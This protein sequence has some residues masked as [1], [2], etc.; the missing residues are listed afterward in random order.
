MTTPHDRIV[1]AIDAAPVIEGE[2]DGVL[3]ESLPPE[4]D[5]PEPEPEGIDP[6]VLARC[7]ALDQNDTDNGARLLAH[8]GDDLIHVREI[9][10]HGW[11]GRHWDAEGGQDRAER[12]AQEVARRIKLESAHMEH[13]PSDAIAM[14]EAEPLR[15]RPAEELSDTEKAILRR[16]DEADERLRK[17]RGDRRK[18]AISSG[19]RSRTVAMIAQAA[20]HCTVAP[21]ALDADPMK[22]NVA[23]GTLVFTKRTSDIIDLEC[24]DPDVTR[25]T[26]EIDVGVALAPHDR[27]DHIAKIAEVA[28]DQ[29]AKCPTFDAFLERF[30]PEEAQRRFL[31]VAAGRALIGGAASQVLIFLY[32]EGANGKSVLMDVISNVLGG[33]AGRLK[34]ES[35]T[36][37]M[38][39][40]GDKATPDFARL[41]GKRFVA[42]AELPR[43]AP[44]REGL[45]KTL[46]GSEPIPVRNLNKGFFDL[47]PEF[48]PWMS[49]NHMPEISGIDRGIWRRMKFVKFP[50]SIP[51]AE[52]KPMPEVV[53]SLMAEASGILNWLVEGALTFLREG[54][55]DPPSV[56]ALNAELKSDAD[57]VGNFLRDCVRDAIW[58]SVQARLL[59]ESFKSYCLA[60]A[61]PVRLE[62]SFSLAMKQK[63]FK[64]EDKRLRRWLDIEVFD[65]PARPDAQKSDFP[66]G[67]GG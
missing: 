36:G 35:I 33:Y 42:I 46:T 40:S 49:G 14:R 57:P 56:Q 25:Y 1:E 9:G 2:A 53:A 10:F 28:F 3:D 30:Q 67:Y 20:P 6:K 29:A 66:D 50:V 39:Q 16:G 11:S 5:M 58:Q 45:V 44:L 12:C 8:F 52:Q 13:F 22:F 17:R 47:L 4:G 18:F 55:I 54:L 61:I 23:N 19:N 21:A 34:P 31:Q 59:Y 26:R 43:G 62:K 27:S 38:E 65:V 37:A 7:A 48:I 64:R 24:P 63:G 32:G 15:A 41:A 51:D 60:N